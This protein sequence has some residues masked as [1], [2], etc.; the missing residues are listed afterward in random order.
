MGEVSLDAL[1]APNVNRQRVARPLSPIK[2]TSMKDTL[3]PCLSIFVLSVRRPM[4][5][6]MK[7]TC[8]ERSGGNSENERIAAS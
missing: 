4:A 8:T 2:S 5:G 3:R 7:V 1:E 6:P